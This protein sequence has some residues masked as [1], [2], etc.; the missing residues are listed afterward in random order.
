MIIIVGKELHNCITYGETVDY[1]SNG[2]PTF[3]GITAYPTEIFETFEVNSIPSGDITEYC[4]T[5]TEGFTTFI[6]PEPAPEPEPTH[7]TLEE[8]TQ[9]ITKE[10]SEN[11]YNI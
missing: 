3:D 2:Y 5:E 7:Y 10:V 9:K 8:A 6:Y 11:G 4:Y 1:W